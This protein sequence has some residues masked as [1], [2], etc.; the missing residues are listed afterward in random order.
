M[1]LVTKRAILVSLAVH[2]LSALAS[3]V[4]GLVVQD[5]TSYLVSD[6]TCTNTESTEQLVPPPEVLLDDAVFTGIRKG[7]TDQFL[8]IPFAYPP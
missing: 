4:D 2:A 1:L 8:G 5:S 6:H 7:A 3:P